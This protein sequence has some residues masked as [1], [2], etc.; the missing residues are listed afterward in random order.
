[1]EKIDKGIGWLERILDLIKKYSI[2]EFLKAFLIILLTALV[3]GFIAKPTYIFEKYDE[4]QTKQH[5]L[6]MEKRLI[7]NE[8]VH[9]LAE[10]L[11]YKVNA[12]RV[13]IL[14]LHNGVSSN[15]GLPFAKASATY[16]AI[17]EGIIPVA[18]QYQDINLSLMPFATKLIEQDYWCGNTEDLM[19]ID[20]ALCYRMLGNDTSHFAGCVIRGV[21][22]PLAF[23]FVKFKSVED[24]HSCEDVKNIINHNALQL[25][26]LLELNKGSN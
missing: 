6:K 2:S 20:K 10:R 3:I 21:D 22:K 5:S 13:L 7:N 1:M 4:W 9:I 25:A 24:N 17:N 26:L 14:E 23:V 12:D 16:E 8:K 11:L 15:S 18:D 19:K